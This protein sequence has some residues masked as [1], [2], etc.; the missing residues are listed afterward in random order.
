[1]P[2]A[3]LVLT[4]PFKAPS[5]V[6][7]KCD[8]FVIGRHH[9]CNLVLEHPSVSKRHAQISWQGE[10][11]Q[12]RD[13]GSK[14]GIAVN[15]VPV[16][17]RPLASD[18][19]IA[20]GSRELI[21]QEVAREQLDADLEDRF[22]KLRTALELT[23]QISGSSMLDKILD[24][25]MAGLLRLTGADRAVLLLDEG[26]GQLQVARSHNITREQWHSEKSGVSSSALRR[27][28]ATGQEVVLSDASG[29]SFFGL[30][31]SVVAQSLKT[32]VCVPIKSDEGVLGLLYADSDRRQQGFEQIDV[33]VL[34]SLAGSAAIALQNQ[35]LN[36][37]VQRL[38]DE[39][40]EVLSQVERAANL[41]ES[42]QLSI[43]QTLT[44]LETLRSR[45]P[46]QQELVG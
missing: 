17:D 32:L 38:V 19:L 8:P 11:W 5:R 23:A 6:L 12:V 16:K 40:S 7:I 9:D 28:L 39:A 45:R 34:H 10:A 2:L 44:A 3:R 22:E 41:E 29:D 1:M 31:Q 43:R 27:A 30:R 46:R 14:N 13:L 35:R 37:Q 4:E 36:Q 21:F 15:G 42:L 20:L 24:Q 26:E 18:D 33:E 25:V